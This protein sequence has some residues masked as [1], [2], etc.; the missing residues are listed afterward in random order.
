MSSGYVSVGAALDGLLGGGIRPGILTHFF[1][2]PASGK[3][4]IALVATS[5]ALGKGKVLYV[6]P[7]GGFSPERLAQIAGDRHRDVLENTLLVKPTTFEEQKVALEKLE[8]IVTS[9]KVGLVIVD[10]IAM[11]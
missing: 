6:D 7:E 2:P 4:N 8:D 3:T 9:I 10:S 11:L 5:N 1:G